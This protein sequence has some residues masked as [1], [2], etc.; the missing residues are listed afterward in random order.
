MGMIFGEDTSITQS[1]CGVDWKFWPLSVSGM[2]AFK[3]LYGPLGSAIVALTETRSTDTAS[4]FREVGDAVRDEDGKPIMFGNRPLRD[5]EN[6]VEAISPELA[7]VRLSQ[8][9]KAI[10]DVVEALM[11]DANKESLAR[12]VI[13]STRLKEQLPELKDGAQC[14]P[15]KSLFDQIGLDAIP[16]LVKGIA[17]ANKGVFGPLTETLGPLLAQV[18]GEVDKRLSENAPNPQTKHGQVSPTPS[19]E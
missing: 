2:Y 6:S 16:D 12:I 11:D 13:D 7:K 4:V 5:T 8:R 1:V 9:E 17:K 18:R 14:P 3:S 10:G 15:A 19:S